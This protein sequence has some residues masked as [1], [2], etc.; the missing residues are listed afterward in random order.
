NPR[1]LSRRGGRTLLRYAGKEF[2]TLTLREAEA[3]TYITMKLKTDQ[4][5]NAEALRRHG[6]TL[7]VLQTHEGQSQATGIRFRNGPGAGQK[8]V[9]G[10]GG[11][12]KKGLG[13]DEEAFICSAT[14][15]AEEGTTESVDAHREEQ[16][17]SPTFRWK[18]H[19]CEPS[20]SSEGTTVAKDPKSCVAEG[21]F[22]QFRLNS[23]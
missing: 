4:R 8:R 15:G 2:V 20:L 21:R 1:K 23:E 12:A 18:E 19:S 14:E 17:Y 9:H 16:D 11:K 7:A 22:A 3:D 13:F 10:R 5:N 6:I